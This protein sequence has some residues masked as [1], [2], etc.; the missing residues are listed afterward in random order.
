MGKV[1]Y[2]KVDFQLLVRFMHQMNQSA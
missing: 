2:D 1:E